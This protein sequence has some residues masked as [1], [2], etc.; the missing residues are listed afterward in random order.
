MVD[1]I[2][3]RAPVSPECKGCAFLLNDVG[4]LKLGSPDGIPNCQTIGVKLKGGGG[5]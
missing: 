4:Q 1:A 2:D 3:G 5:L